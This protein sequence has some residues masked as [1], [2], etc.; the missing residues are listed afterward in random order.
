MSFKSFLVKRVI[1]F[2]RIPYQIRWKKSVSGIGIMYVSILGMIQEKYGADGVENLNE[3]MYDIGFQQSTEILEMLD[4][5]KN[6]EGCAYVVLTMH[7]IFGIKSKI[8]SQEH[9]RIILHADKCR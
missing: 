7:R 9:N 5:E 6:L 3:A 1:K 8:V 2:D 4:L